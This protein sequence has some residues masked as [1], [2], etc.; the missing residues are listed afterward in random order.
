MSAVDLKEVC[1]H[2]AHYDA[3]VNHTL[4]RFKSSCKSQ[5]PGKPLFL[6]ILGSS[7]MTGACHHLRPAAVF[8]DDRPEAQKAVLSIAGA[9]IRNFKAEIKFLRK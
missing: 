6:P 2:A 1:V 3:V 9:K 5:L 7:L 4:F 8:Y